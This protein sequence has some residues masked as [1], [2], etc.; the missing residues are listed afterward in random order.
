[1]FVYKTVFSPSTKLTVCIALN[2]VIQIV[3]KQIDVSPIIT[4]RYTI[5]DSFEFNGFMYLCEIH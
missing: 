1:M 3:F 5:F 4:S 2:N